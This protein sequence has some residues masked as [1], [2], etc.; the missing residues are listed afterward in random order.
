MTILKRV[1]TLEAALIPRNDTGYK[2]VLLKEGESSEEDIMGSGLKDWPA[3]RILV[4]RFVSPIS[5]WLCR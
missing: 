4:L 3:E 1:E 5:S 2:L